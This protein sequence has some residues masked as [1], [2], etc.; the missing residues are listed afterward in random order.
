M[1]SAAPVAAHVLGATST[2]LHITENPANGAC[3]KGPDGEDFVI[4]NLGDSVDLSIAPTE[5]AP[6]TAMWNLVK[7]QEPVMQTKIC[8]VDKASTSMWGEYRSSWM[9]LDY[10]NKQP[11]TYSAMKG[12]RLPLTLRAT[13]TDTRTFSEFTLWYAL[14]N[15]VAEAPT[16][17]H[18]TEGAV[19]NTGERV[20]A[21]GLQN[22]RGF[23]RSALHTEYVMPTATLDDA[24]GN[25]RT[26]GVTGELYADGSA[27]FTAK[28]VPIDFVHG[29]ENLFTIPFANFVS[30]SP[31]LEL[32]FIGTVKK[33]TTT[34]EAL[35]T[36]PEP[37]VLQA[38]ESSTLGGLF[39]GFGFTRSARGITLSGK[40]VYDNQYHL[41]AHHEERI[42]PEA[43][44]LH[45]VLKATDAASGLSAARNLYIDVEVRGC[46]DVRASFTAGVRHLMSKESL[47]LP[48]ELQL[49][50]AEST[51]RNTRGNFNA[52]ATIP[53]ACVMPAKETNPTELTSIVH[54]GSRTESSVTEVEAALLRDSSVS[55][56][57]SA[58]GFVAVH[59]PGKAT[60]E[61]V[62]IQVEGVADEVAAT[63]SAPASGSL[64]DAGASVKLG[65][66]GQQFEED[67]EVCM[68]VGAGQE[69]RHFVLYHA[70]AVS[71]EDPSLGYSEFQPTTGNVYNPTTGKVCGKIRSFSIV[72]S[73]SLPMPV[74]TALDSRFFEM[75]GGCP[76]GCSNKGYCRAYGKCFCFEG[77]TGYDCSQ[78]TC[79]E[80]ESWVVDSE[81]PQESS[82]CSGRGECDRGSGE[83][84]CYGG[85][86]GPACERMSCENDCSG[87]GRCRYISELTNSGSYTAWDKSRI[88]SCSCDPGYFGS[89]CSLRYCP[90][91]DDPQTHCVSA[92]DSVQ[93]ISLKFGTEANPVTIATINTALSKT[94]VLDYSSL[95]L[96][97]RDAAGNQYDTAPVHRFL[98]TAST[99]A[100]L[101]TSIVAALKDLPNFIADDGVG[102]AVST[103]AADG[104]DR[105][106]TFTMSGDRNSGDT[107]TVSC[108]ASSTA[109]LGT[110]GCPHAGCRP[111]YQQI[112]ASV[113]ET[114]GTA[115]HVLIAEPTLIQGLGANTN[116]G[117]KLSVTVAAGTGHTSGKVFKAEVQLIDNTG[118]LG[119]VETT[120][121][122]TDRPVPATPHHATP[123]DV[124][125]G[126]NI[127]FANTAPADGVYDWYFLLG[128]CERA[129]TRAATHQREGIECSGRGVCDRSSGQCQCFEGY[130]GY[131][132]GVRSIIV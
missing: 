71:C 111:R 98:E 91:G 131:H 116:V 129:T 86:E 22:G 89:D 106:V 104:D 14:D 61:A 73:V 1:A 32:S 85:F 27:E 97:W 107:V 123:I 75:G 127:K 66:C 25:V 50:N 124:G 62:P 26:D 5:G 29:Q 53:A 12:H 8:V 117:L 36:N 3:L 92:T 34:V 100:A 16:F 126:I 37:I 43:A 109:A 23:Y 45:F 64:V 87:H 41:Q 39:E 90:F 110:Y 47:K 82:E 83:C 63:M 52:R 120:G 80:G 24:T 108:P 102:V 17:V 94:L 55:A 69:D 6:S 96:T 28:F 112:R 125:F 2:D 88:Q 38:G 15:V 51:W 68:F 21:S 79:P 11:N 57:E 67:V 35:K 81:V 65:P 103:S 31:E 76:N 99:P 70:S 93:T 101:K 122:E 46:M 114:T 130:H 77:F 54:A 105:T 74:A 49:Y 60:V 113:S 128:H 132:C 10:E 13:N 33:D 121:M 20:H 4:E 18:P 30:G 7:S 19:M 78:R 95:V 72:S 58:R 115:G 48:R 59:V 44:R 9:T 56:L 118:A 84:Q 42:S 119:T 40:P